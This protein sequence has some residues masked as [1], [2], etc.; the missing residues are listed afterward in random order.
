M[1]QGLYIAS[2]GP[3]SGKSLAVL[4]MVDALHRHAGRLGFFRPLVA[5]DAVDDD[6]VVLLLRRL[7]ELGA[8]RS[9]AGTTTPAALAEAR[10][11]QQDELVSRMIGIYSRLSR[12]CDA[13]VVDGSD[14]R[15]PDAA[16][17]FELNAALASNLGLPVLAVVGGRGVPPARI[18]ESVATALKQFKA[19]RCSVLAVVVNRVEPGTE[20]RVEQ[21]LREAAPDVPC[22]LIPEV[23]EISTPTVADIAES[24]RLVPSTGSK[25]WDR[26][27]RRIRVAGMGADDFLPAVQTGD[28]VLASGDR[29]DIILACLASALAPDLPS[30]G[31][32]ILTDGLQPSPHVKRLLERAPFPV[33]LE[34][35]DLYSVAQG[36]A[37]VRSEIHTGGKRKVAAALGLWSRH[38]P[39]ADLLKEL[40]LPRPSTIT[41]LRFFNDLIERAR[42]RTS[43]VVLAEGE[44]VRILR[45]ADILRRRDVC[46]LTLLGRPEVVSELAATQG[47]E[48]GD[49]A[50]IDPATSPDRERFAREYCKLRANKGMIMERARE[51]MLDAAYF[52]TMMVRLGCADGMVSGAAHTTANTIRPAL[53]FI[54]GEDPQE[55]VSSVFFMLFPDR[56]LVYGDC[57]VVPDP[58]AGELAGIAIASA[59]TAE[60]FGVEPRVAM[61]SYSTGE[62]GAGTSVDK[63]REAT[64][65][66]RASRPGL[67][68][69]GPIQYDAAVDVR[70]A[71]TK[72]PSSTV[73]GKATVFIFPDLDTGNNTYKAVEHSAGAIAVGPILQGLR[74]PINDLSRGSSV[75]DII[76]T[77]A[78]TAV[79]AQG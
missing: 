72:L 60:R 13:V 52:G 64:A 1:V 37:S 71:S 10:S 29:T 36:A 4:G 56:V 21:A 50:V 31:G 20:E 79:Q 58:T 27:I 77:V 22:Y 69:E 65:L 67:P 19:A 59:E 23:A 43:H 32:M 70:I 61:L 53:E 45:A 17:E 5:G 54:K 49:L 42:Q 40:A 2:A 46:R 78:I 35:G 14:L 62:S 75:E 57:A 25:E 12:G 7:Y 39:E 68:V 16:G 18:G 74:K 3:G 9:K 8:S 24:L 55:V 38:I 63:V 33:F 11:G 34:R 41:P 73:A 48:L 26:D 6:P 30:P 28:M 15:S 76:N 47:I 66:V 44:D 51:I